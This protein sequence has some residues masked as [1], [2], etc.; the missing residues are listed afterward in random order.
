LRCD[1]QG[2]ELAGFLFGQD[3]PEHR[4]PLRGSA[5]LT[6]LHPGELPLPVRIAFQT[7]WFGWA[8]MYLTGA[9]DGAPE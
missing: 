3:D 2:R 4:Q 6:P 5:W 8:T 7:R 9:V 1:F